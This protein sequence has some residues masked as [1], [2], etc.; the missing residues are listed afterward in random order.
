[1]E[2]GGID[3]RQKDIDLN[4]HFNFLFEFVSISIFT[5]LGS[6]SHAD[7]YFVVG[8]RHCSPTPPILIPSAAITRL[9]AR[10]PRAHPFEQSSNAG[11]N[12]TSPP[13]HCNMLEDIASD[14]VDGSHD[15][16]VSLIP[17]QILYTFHRVAQF[18]NGAVYDRNVHD[19]GILA[20]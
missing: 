15:I 4:L 7:S 5:Q 11:S 13:P 14:L 1:M 2:P 17:Q 9:G 20:G 3:G 19:L 16:S 8:G 10:P 12:H 6:S 18:L